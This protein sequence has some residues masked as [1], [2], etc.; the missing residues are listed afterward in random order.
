MS[1]WDAKAAWILAFIEAQKAMPDIVKRQTAEIPTGGGKSYSYQYADLPDIL[2]TVKPT[3]L[4][5]GL[6]VAQSVTAEGGKI[7][8]ETRIYHK[9]GHTESFG[10]LELDGAGDARRAGSAITYA[11]RYALTAALGL[12][13]E[14]DDDGAR[15]SQP[16][17]HDFEQTGQAWLAN[18]VGVF[19]LWTPE[20]RTEQGKAAVQKVDAKKPLSMDDARR[21]YE[22]MSEVYYVEFPDALPF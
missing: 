16:Q 14:D 9:D 20:Q 12:A 11:R 15:A 1:E 21:V 19:G 2:A 7:R 5:H 17:R 8:V 3:L 10:P 13:P 22:A 18:A 6:T 4:E